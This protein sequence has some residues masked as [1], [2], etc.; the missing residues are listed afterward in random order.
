MRWRLLPWTMAGAAIATPVLP[1]M[2]F[3]QGADFRITFW[4][5]GGLAVIL[6]GAVLKRG[7]PY[8]DDLMLTTT[9]RYQLVKV[10]C[11]A[12]VTLPRSAG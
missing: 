7:A 2:F 9:P 8:D 10:C 5:C 6:A 11:S 3:G 4:V 12:A 1:R